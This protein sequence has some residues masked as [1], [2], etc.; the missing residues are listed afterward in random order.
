MP[1]EPAWIAG[2][3]C[4]SSAGAPGKYCATNTGATPCTINPRATPSRLPNVPSARAC[5][6]KI[7]TICRDCAPT[8]F[9]MAIVSSLCWMCACIA[10]ATPRPPTI[11]AIRLTRL[12]KLTARSR[13]RRM[14]GCVSRKSATRAPG[15]PSRSACRV[16][17]TER[18]S[19][20]S[21]NRN[22]CEARLPGCIRPVRSSAS[23]ESMTR[24]PTFM[25]PVMRSGST[26][27][28]PAMRNSSLPRRTASP[29]S[30]PSRSSKS[31]ETTT[32]AAVRAARNSCGGASSIS[33]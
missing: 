25:L 24:G 8:H 11:M 17:S 27:R 1:M 12:R 4:H 18:P 31:S 10:V 28:T 32:L 30:T 26:V 2:Q 21:L 29:T 22:R 20:G 19:A 33:P 15:S 6:A 16:S 14:V 7:R 3:G 13:P 5:S 9:M 23:A